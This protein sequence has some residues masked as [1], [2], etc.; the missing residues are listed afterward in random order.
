MTLWDVKAGDEVA[1]FWDGKLFAEVRTVERATPKYLR[2]RGAMWS[3]ETGRERGHYYGYGHI[4]ALTDE[5]RQRMAALAQQLADENRKYKL[6][7]A[8][9]VA[10]PRATLNA[11]EAAATALGATPCN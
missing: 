6:C 9:Q 8:I 4:E 1:W 11:L 2:V 5:T 10:M 7:W 3:R